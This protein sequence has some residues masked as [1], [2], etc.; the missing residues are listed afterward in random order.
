MVLHAPDCLGCC[1]CRDKR[2]CAV[3]N[4]GGADVGL[5]SAQCFLRASKPES[6]LRR[7]YIPLDTA[8][9]GASFASRFHVPPVVSRVRRMRGLVD[10]GLPSKPARRPA[11]PAPHALSTHNSAISRRVRSVVFA[12]CEGPTPWPATSTT[13]SRAFAH[14]PRHSLLS[15][16]QIKALAVSGMSP[17]S[18]ANGRV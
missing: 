12:L 16:Q 5:P 15:P 14:S 2:G 4:A 11:H 1:E 9:R 6:I 17:C 13:T 10:Q 3:I 18:T 8:S 7:V